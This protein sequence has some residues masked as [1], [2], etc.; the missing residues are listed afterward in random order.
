MR[1]LLKAGLVIMS[2]I[3]FANVAAAFDIGHDYIN[4]K[5]MLGENASI[6]VYLTI[7]ANERLPVDYFEMF[8]GNLKCKFIAN[9]S[10]V[11]GCDGIAIIQTENALFTQGALTGRYLGQ[12]YNWGNGFG[13]GTDENEAM[14]YNLMVNSSLLGKGVFNASF[15]VKIGNNVFEKKGESLIVIEPVVI[16][17]LAPSDGCVLEKEGFEIRADIQGSLKEVFVSIGDGIWERNVSLGNKGAGIYRYNVNESDISIGNFRWRFFARDIGDNFIYGSENNIN[18]NSRTKL[19]VLPASPYGMNEWYVD[20]PRFVLSNPEAIQIR[21]SW[22]GEYYDYNGEFGLGGLPNNGNRTGG[23]FMLRYWSNI[24]NESAQN[25][26]FRFDFTNPFIKDI[27]PKGGEIVFDTN[28]PVISARIDET[29]QGNSGINITSV[30]VKLDDATLSKS[31][32]NVSIVDKIDA[33]IVLIP[34]NNLSD[35]NHSV[36][37]SVMDFAG[38]TGSL[39]WEFEVDLQPSNFSINMFS[40]KDGVFDNRRVLVNLTIT[41][42]IKELTYINLNDKNPKEK[43]LCKDCDE[44]GNLR[45]KFLSLNE[46]ENNLKI[47]ARDERGG[48]MEKEIDIVIDTKKPRIS[49]TEPKK[50]SV[51]NG[52]VFRVTYTEENV[53]FVE[54]HYGINGENILTKSCPSGKNVVCEFNLT[55]TNLSALDGKT[56]IYY[57]VIGDGMN[58]VSSREIRVKIDTTKPDLIVFSPLDG[59]NYSRY[60]PFRITAG[61]QSLIEFMDLDAGTEWERLCKN[62][63]SWGYNK[64]FEMYLTRGAHDYM[65]R[66]TDTAGNSAEKRV[67]FGVI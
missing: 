41:K 29:Y 40:P 22:N 63:D 53:K 38:R 45:K 58:N 7:D 37:I 27:N 36:E 20:K 55:S 23:T 65:I 49:K 2:L 13:Y 59:E 17:N 4:D 67:S 60:V 3:L 24:C 52:E 15:R 8:L 5:V 62:C 12:D 61:E 51:T 25:R 10:G 56:I 1:R 64:K 57:F 28:R 50:D 42:K 19:E 54:L 30:I 18:I 6:N 34:K 66:A 11:I 32:Y 16:N 9:G 26:T 46:G 31:D 35:G 47:I 33:E 14:R 48:E 43:R 21:Y 39:R 44:Y